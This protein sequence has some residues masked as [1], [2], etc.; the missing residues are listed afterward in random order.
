MAR[1]EPP[2]GTVTFLFTDIEG[3]TRLTHDLGKEWPPLLER[4]RRIARE[5]WLE[6]GGVEISTEGDS[7]FVVVAT[8]AS[9]VAAAVQTQRDLA[10]EQWPSG[11]DIRVR[12]GLHTGEGHLGGG[13]YVGIDVHRAARIAAAGHGG[14]V[15]L[16]ASTHA[17]LEGSGAWP[18]GVEARDLGKH[19]LKDLSRPERIYELTIAGL[20]S[21]FPPIRTLN[22]VRN[23]LPSQLTSFLG[24]DR[25]LEEA[26]HLLV[27][28]R[29]L[30]LVGPGGTGK[31]RLALQTAAAAADTYPDG[32]YFVPLGMVT[33]AALVLPTL[34]QALGLLQP[35]THRLDRLASYL[36]AKRVLLLLDNF[37]QILDAAPTVA[38]LLG[39]VAQLS[40]LV[41]SRSPLRVYGER[42][43]HVPRLRVPDPH[44]IPALAELAAFDSVALFVERAQGVRADF[45]LG[46]ENAAAV[47]EICARLDGLPLAIELAAAR[48]RALSPQAIAQRLDHRLSL[49]PGGARDLPQRQQTLR[50]AIAWSHDLLDEADQRF[51]ARFSVFAGGADL[52]AVEEV[53][54]D[55]EQAGSALD[56]IE[57]LL[58]KSLVRL[59]TSPLGE[60]RYGMLETIREFAFQ[61]LIH[62]G[63]AGM[64]CE[65]Q[66][67]WA[68]NFAERESRSV[69]GVDRREVLDRYEIEHDNIRSAL[70]WALA[71]GRAPLAM[72]IFTGTWRFW[73]SRGFIT[74]ARRY[75]ERVMALPV[76][77]DER[78]HRA[79]A[80]E[81]AAGIAYW[82]GDVDAS[83]RWYSEA[84]ALARESGDPSKI[85]NALY[86]VSFP[87]AQTEGGF[88]AAKSVA[89]EAIELYRSIGDDE[90]VGR[91]LWGLGS[92][93]YVVNDI[94]G[95]LALAQQALDIF[96]GGEDQFMTAW[97]HYLVGVLNLNVD[98]AKMRRAPPCCLPALRADQRHV[99]PHTRLRCACHPRVARRRGGAGYA[100]GWLRGKHRAHLRHRPGQDEPRSGRLLTRVSG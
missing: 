23:N 7:F 87:L 82:Q 63:E 1:D 88:E 26:R 66:A 41:T 58:D 94:D 59:E 64:I 45:K 6:H 72:R 38:D 39:R 52:L 9:A 30:T 47:A 27:Q 20:N 76:S 92:A 35:G 31:T 61:Q 33:D 25:E 34:A 60:V 73:Q 3:S 48:V 36:A 5:S 67:E 13:S 68:A 65:R 97:A 43:Y 37:E 21:Q 49:L 85:A 17:L 55:P 14:Q 8:A 62:R 4:H 11:V 81:A 32:V 79:T 100:P 42:E 75:A 71:A 29:L 86:N 70:T 74:E 28:T 18:P 57:S 10:G 69:L 44:R 98:G 90:G 24:R 99:R 15:L 80:V 93:Y 12:M 53:V 83:L 19:A 22:A 56:D 40:V 89:D 16:S 78:G 91:V 95:G 77:P 84:L 46:V 54:C 51:F 2:T 50:G 96:N